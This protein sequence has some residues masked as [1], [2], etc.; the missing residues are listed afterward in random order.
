MGKDFP[1]VHA[2]IKEYSKP[3]ANSDTFKTAFDSATDISEKYLRDKTVCIDRVYRVLRELNIRWLKCKM[4]L[5]T[6]LL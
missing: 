6:R 1:T 5:D 2:I 4:N 3:Q